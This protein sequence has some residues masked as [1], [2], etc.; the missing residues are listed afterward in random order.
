VN[1]Q[2]AEDV[3]GCTRRT[4]GQMERCEARAPDAWLAWLA[5]VR[6]D[7]CGRVRLREILARIVLDRSRRC[8]WGKLIATG[9]IRRRGCGVIREGVE[10]HRRSAGGD[11]G[12]R[13]EVRLVCRGGNTEDGKATPFYS[14]SFYFN[15]VTR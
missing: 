3:G 4:D 1:R 10:G 5:P 15:S 8:L 7:M 14:L 13:G 2:Q 12:P 6:A 9:L 11:R